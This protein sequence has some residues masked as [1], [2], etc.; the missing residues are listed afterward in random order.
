ME[1]L[2]ERSLASRMPPWISPELA[3][4]LHQAL[5][6]AYEFGLLD[7]EEAEQVLKGYVL[8]DVDGREWSIGATSGRWYSRSAGGEW[9]WG[10]PPPALKPPD[11]DLSRHLARGRAPS[12]SETSQVAAAAV[13]GGP[14]GGGTSGDATSEAAVAPAPPTPSAAT[15]ADGA[16][17]SCGTRLGMDE[18]FCTGCGRPAP[19]APRPAALC[20]ACGAQNQPGSRFCISC[21]SPLLPA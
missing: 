11:L 6:F 12:G 5:R 8:R 1:S 21:G 20:G 17:P 16:C 15:V 9:A 19:P 14:P 7:R 3:Q 13:K 10:E 4:R 2:P 18:R